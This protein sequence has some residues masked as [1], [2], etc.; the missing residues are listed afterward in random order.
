MLK[1]E[2][3]EKNRAAAQT[4][5]SNEHIKKELENLITQIP[6][7]KEELFYYPINWTLFATVF[8]KNFLDYFINILLIL[9]YSRAIF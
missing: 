8:F 2:E 7:T 6:K 5:L 1:E 3:I 9:F 4:I